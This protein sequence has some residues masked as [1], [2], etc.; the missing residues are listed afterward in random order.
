[1]GLQTFQVDLG[2]SCWLFGH[3]GPGELQA[4]QKALNLGDEN[5]EGKNGSRE[6]NFGK[7]KKAKNAK[8]LKWEL[9][10]AREWRIHGKL[11]GAPSPTGL[12][13]RGS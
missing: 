3:G 4:W 1:M 6:L 5:L 13:K 12:K 8:K 9:M 7:K 10:G 11:V 2:H